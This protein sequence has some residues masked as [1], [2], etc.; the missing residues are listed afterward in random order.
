MKRILLLAPFVGIAISGCWVSI[1]YG[2]PPVE[3][4]ELLAQ[5]WVRSYEEEDPSE[6]GEI[7]RVK[8]FR[9]F[10]PSW[11]RMRYEFFS[12]GECRWLWLSPVDA[13]EMRPGTW[14]LDSQNVV[15][16]DV[17]EEIRSYRIIELTPKLLRWVRLEA[18]R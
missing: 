16:I 1:E 14:R 17:G 15:H 18:G 13:H 6:P 5:D 9:E 12:N 7:F 4:E 10:P 2:T 3:T 11:F 8:G